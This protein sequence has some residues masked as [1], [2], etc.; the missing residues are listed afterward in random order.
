MFLG[1]N[2]VKLNPAIPNVEVHT[3]VMSW[4]EGKYQTG[5]TGQ[6]IDNGI[7]ISVQGTAP[8]VL[9]LVARTKNIGGNFSAE[10]YT[11]PG[12]RLGEFGSPA[13]S[14]LHV[15]S[16]VKDNPYYD[17]RGNGLK[18]IKG[19]TLTVFDQ[20]TMDGAALLDLKGEGDWTSMMGLSFCIADGK[21]LGLVSWIIRKDYG[22]NPVYVVKPIYP[23]PAPVVQSSRKVLA[24]DGYA[25][26]ELWLPLQGV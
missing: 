10:T 2:Q 21:L 19:N 23:V 6:A 5:K 22:N 14:K 12:G 7:T 26:P 17:C 24:S 16:R 11:A 15:D 13:D 18:H 1:G 3:G 8:H 9:Q 20:P 25:N 4:V